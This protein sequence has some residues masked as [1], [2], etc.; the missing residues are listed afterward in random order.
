MN[1]AKYISSLTLYEWVVLFG[2]IE[3]PEIRERVPFRPW[4]GQQDFLLWTEGRQE[5]W[6]P[7]ARQLGLSEIGGE[8]LVKSAIAIPG[9]QYVVISKTEDDAIYFL[10][11]RVH[12]KFQNLPQVEGITWPTVEKKSLTQ[13]KL[14][15]GS[16]IWSLPAANASGASRTLNGFIV[17]EAGGIDKQPNCKFAT[18]YKNLIPTIEKSNGWGMVIGTSEPGSFFNAQLYK[19]YTGVTDAMYYFLSWR[20]DPARNE[21]WKRRKVSTYDTES[22]FTNQYPESMA[23][24]FATREGRVFPTFDP[25]HGGLHIQEFT[26]DF[27]HKLYVMYDHGFRHYAAAVYALYDDLAD[28]VYIFD[29]QFWKGVDI[30]DIASQVLEKLSYIPRVPE[31]MIADT[32][33]FNKDARRSVADHFLDHG[34]R[35]QHAWKADEAGSRSMLSERFT[36]GRIV[37]HPK[38]KDVITQ[39]TNYVWSTTSKGE[40]PVD[41]NDEAPDVLR[42]LCAHIRK[43]T[44]PPPKKEEIRQEYGS[45]LG[46]TGVNSAKV[47]VWQ[48][49]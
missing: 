3:N 37:I 6:C 40:R 21:A 2:T 31:A 32:Q 29:E 11:E 12:K 22:D 47:K 48:A 19:Q 10:E 42:Y 35:W 24:F 1:L 18:L 43:G 46:E 7:K 5:I 23:E 15:N 9:S 38:C 27:R 28:M 20:T 4:K 25:T 17:D 30:G 45:R 41:V 13:I 14:S 33:I 44:P 8:K 49:L 39:L 34:L 16:V 26:P 36:K